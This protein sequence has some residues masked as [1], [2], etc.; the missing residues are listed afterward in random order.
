MKHLG[1]KNLETNRLLLRRLELKDAQAM[2]DNWCSN[3]NVA[4]YVCWEVHKNVDETKALLEEW[5][6]NYES[7]E[8]YK[9]VAEIKDTSEI[10]GTIDVVSKKFL[11]YGACEIGYC[12]GEDYWNKGYGTECLK[13]VMKYLFEECDAEVI[14]AKHLSQN[15]GS[16]KVMMKCGL[17]YEG[18]LRDRFV[19]KDGIRND[20]LSYSITKDEYKTLVFNK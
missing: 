4:K 17:K 13:A 7:N 9:W 16:G 6:K 15:P 19:D 20:L 18:T 10:I 2:Y 5:I 1:T 8:T 12:Y 11:S 14:F 3:P